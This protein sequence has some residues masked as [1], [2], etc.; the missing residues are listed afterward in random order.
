MFKL[1]REQMVCHI[2]D[3][4]VG[5]QPGERPTV[6]VGSIFFA[7]HRIVQDPQRGLFDELKAQTLLVSEEEA[8]EF[9]GNPRFVDPVADTSEALIR[10]IKFLSDK[11]TAPILVDSPLATVRLET[12]RHFAGTN[13]MPRLIYNSISEDSTEGELAAIRESGIESAILLAFSTKAMRPS[14]RVRLLEEKLIPAA[15][16]AGIKNMLVDVGVLD[17]ASASWSA[18][19][20]REVK[21]ALGLPTGCAPA[22]AMCTWEKAKARGDLPYTAAM[23]TTLA[24]MVSQGADFLLYGP[25]RFAPWV[26][27]AVGA[28]NALQ[29]YAG[30]IT[31]VRPAS[32]QHPMFRV[33]Q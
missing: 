4:Q 29:G 5:G 33:L 22:N 2:G 12:L 32:D 9:S 23:A 21:S 6:L 19:S 3:V 1:D 30:R 10:Y 25:M 18:L 11:T 17:I 31:G 8:S 26:Y 27:S 24:M 7:R 15:H 13:L 16:S 14:Q 28:A 20:I